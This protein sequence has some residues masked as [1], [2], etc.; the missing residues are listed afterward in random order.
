MNNTGRL[1]QLRSLLLTEV[2]NLRN[3]YDD[4]SAS[5]TFANTNLVRRH[6]WNDYRRDYVCGAQVE[7]KNAT[8]S[9]AR[10]CSYTYGPT[11]HLSI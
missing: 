4:H 11:M 1:S 5:P 7:K 2:L 9:A 6:R 10:R 3:V 8:L